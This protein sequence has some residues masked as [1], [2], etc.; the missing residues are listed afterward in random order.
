MNSLVTH[1]ATARDVFDG[2]IGLWVAT[3]LISRIPR[4]RQQVRG[5]FDPTRVLIGVSLAGGF[6]L[7]FRAAGD[8]LWMFGGG[9]PSIAVG[10]AI[11]ASGVVFRTW[12]IVTLGRF[13]TY[14]VTIQPGHRVVTSGPYRWVR[15]PS[16]TGGLVGLLGLGVALGSAAAVLA[17]VVVPLVGLLIRVR[18]EERT[19][20]T[21]LGTEYDAY[22]AGR[23]RLLPGIW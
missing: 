18:H 9:W 22:A 21:A 13:F 2:F 10:L 23:P 19:L 16:Y 11:A 8:R 15:H 1:S 3:E 7:A 4:L 17:L 5:T 12:A 6:V 20:R 14:D